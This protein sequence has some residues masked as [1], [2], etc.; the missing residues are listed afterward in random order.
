[1]P[2]LPEPPEQIKKPVHIFHDQLRK[3]HRK[4]ALAMVR[5]RQ[6]KGN[7][8]PFYEVGDIVALVRDL[9]KPMKKRI[10]NRKAKME[11]NYLNMGFRITSV[12]DNHQ[13][14]LEALDKSEVPH[15]RKSFCGSHLRL[16]KRRDKI[17]DAIIETW[18]R[19]RV[20][21]DDLPDV[22]KQPNTVPSNENQEHSDSSTEEAPF[23]EPP[24]PS[25]NN[26]G[27]KRKLNSIQN[28]DEID[29]NRSYIP[30][31]KRQFASPTKEGSQSRMWKSIGI[32]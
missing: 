7:G 18:T 28:E 16:I 24:L 11:G 2:D 23:I 21:V 9:K 4:K 30:R 31:K 27:S 22:L 32:H 10:T 3:N 5:K 17:T 12:L 29:E 26:K 25:N 15:N 20:T 1:M 13:Y 8:S 14:C 19:K 6:A